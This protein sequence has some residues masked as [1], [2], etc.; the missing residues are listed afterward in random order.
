MNS[1]TLLY[2]AKTHDLQIMSAVFPYKLC[3]ITQT[4]DLSKPSYVEYYVFDEEKQ[5]LRRKRVR[6]LQ[7]TFELREKA[8]KQISKEIDALLKKGVTINPKPKKAPPAD[9]VTKAS[10]IVDA[11]KVYLAFV[12]KTLKKKTYESYATDMKR[13]LLYLQDTKKDD[14]TISDFDEVLAFHF[15]DYLI[16]VKELS[17]RSRNNTRGT[18]SSF[19]S[20]FK[21]RKII[22]SNPFDEIANLKTIAKRHAALDSNHARRMKKYCTEHNEKELLLYIYFIYYCFIRSGSELRELRIR[23]IKEGSIFIAGDRAKN[24][25][26][27]FIKIPSVFQTIINEYKLSEYPG[28]YFIFS[29][30]G[31]PGLEPMGRDFMYDRH[32]EVLLHLNLINK[33][34]T[35]YSWKHTGVISLWKA[36]QNIELLREHCRHRDVAITTKYLRDLG[37]FIDYDQINK[38]PEL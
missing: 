20:F 34:Y 38:F 25:T 26:G 6:L 1:A 18:V 9:V 13:F 5:E 24:N 27:E 19:F 31:K 32:K 4:D 15:L 12:E 30:D 21:K 37:L 29:I 2:L 8:G 14:K 7:P 16:T 11:S 33:N 3:R 22:L 17:N 36:T 23:D 35:I 10:L 28:H